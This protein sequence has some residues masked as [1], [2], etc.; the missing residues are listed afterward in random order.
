MH[1]LIHSDAALNKNTTY[2][3]LAA[4]ALWLLYDCFGNCLTYTLPQ[5]TGTPSKLTNFTLLNIY[6]PTFETS[7]EIIFNSKAGASHNFSSPRQ[8]RWSCDLDGSCYHHITYREGGKW[9]VVNT[10]T[11]ML[12]WGTLH[13]ELFLVCF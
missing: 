7:S 2:I 8:N 9:L 12:C 4:V 11:S 10:H 1:Q 13:G 3:V 6:C 5:N